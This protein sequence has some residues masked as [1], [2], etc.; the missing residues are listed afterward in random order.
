METKT[1]TEKT[2]RAT[3]SSK[4][5]TLQEDPPRKKLSSSPSTAEP[6]TPINT[7]WLT[8]NSMVIT[9]GRE[10]EG[11]AKT[12][13]QKDKTSRKIENT[14]LPMLNRGSNNTEKKEESLKE[15]EDTMVA[16]RREE[17]SPTEE[18]KVKGAILAEVTTS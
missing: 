5:T 4:T 18:K 15:I 3:R 10:E 16:G 13:L 9:L 8:L 17:S 2:N 7:A 1:E 11:M 12:S 14:L 6:T